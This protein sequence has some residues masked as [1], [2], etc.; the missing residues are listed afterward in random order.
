MANGSEKS[1][2]KML[3]YP[4]AIL[5]LLAQAGAERAGRGNSRLR[6]D[7]TCRGVRRGACFGPTSAG[8]LSGRDRTGGAGCTGLPGGGI[9]G[10]PRRG[11]ATEKQDRRASVESGVVVGRGPGLLARLSD[12]MD[13]SNLDGSNT[14]AKVG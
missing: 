5:P 13:R 4:S 12:L 2:V 11:Q 8:P 3:R 10:L 1:S 6:G 9:R 14:Q 7:G